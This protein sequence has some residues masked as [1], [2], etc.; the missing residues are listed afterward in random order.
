MALTFTKL[1]ALAGLAILTLGVIPDR[2]K[3][4]V[5]AIATCVAAAIVLHFAAP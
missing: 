4:A 2:R 5:I 3:G 1:A